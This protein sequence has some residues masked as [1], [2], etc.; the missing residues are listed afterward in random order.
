M[1]DN[2]PIK[3]ARSKRRFHI[4]VTL[5]LALAAGVFTLIMKKGL[6][7]DHSQ[8]PSVLLE[9]P[10]KQFSVAW[11]QGKDIIGHS[12]QTH[13][14]LSDLKGRPMIVNFWAS[15]CY[16][17]RQE[18]KDFEAF[19][20]RYRSSDLV[21]VGIAIQDT[22]EAALSFAR[23]YGKSYILGLDE[24]GKAAIDYGVTGVPETFVI[25]REG[26]VI[27]K[28]AGPMTAEKLSEVAEKLF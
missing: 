22:P 26:Q 21:V 14:S 19:W 27:Y 3:P 6:D 23:Q 4:L 7:L 18:A 9:K 16:S 13:L 25:N 10:A 2:A 24:D 20:Q 28:E 17:C 5:G 8:I 15:W 12:E 1:T 11:L